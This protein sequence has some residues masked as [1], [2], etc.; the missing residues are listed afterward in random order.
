LGAPSIIDKDLYITWASSDQIPDP[1]N[2]PTLRRAY[3]ESTGD[4]PAFV[5]DDGYSI[6]TGTDAVVVSG[7]AVF[8]QVG[9]DLDRGAMLITGSAAFAG[10]SKGL[11][12][13][14]RVPAQAGR[15]YPYLPSGQ[16]YPCS[17]ESTCQ[18]TDWQGHLL[19]VDFRGFLYVQ[20]NLVV[21]R[22]TVLSGV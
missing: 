20:R 4:D 11:P 22:D 16:N 12:L 9:M 6:T 13:S 15:E 1:L 14:L 18:P 5:A 21:L 8:G 3:F 17:G 2:P 19:N 7:D 10:K